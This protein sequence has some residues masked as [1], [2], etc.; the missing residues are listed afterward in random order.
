MIPQILGEQ[1]NTHCEFV[2]TGKPASSIAVQERYIDDVCVLVDSFNLNR[3]IE[4]LSDGWK[5]V[6]I[7]RYPHILEVIKESPQVPKSK[8]DH[9]VLG[10]L[11]GYDEVSIQ[12]FLSKHA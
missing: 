6:W 7:Y 1:I 2:K 11:F 10:K 8:Y 3:Y 4:S 9:W 12:D 5:T